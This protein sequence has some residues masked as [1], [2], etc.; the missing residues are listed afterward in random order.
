M[1]DTPDKFEI[2]KDHAAAI[3]YVAIH[4]SLV[5]DH[6]AWLIYNLLGLQTMPG[7]AMTAELPTMQRLVLV[8]TLINLTG[9][10]TWAA[11]WA[12][13]SNEA[14]R[15]RAE[16]NN[17]VHAIWI[18]RDV[19]NRVKAKGKVDFQQ[20]QMKTPEITAKANEILALS[21]KLALFNIEV[22]S[23]GAAKILRQR[24]LP[25]PILPQA[26]LQQSRIR[27]QKRALKETQRQASRREL[28][29]Q[30]EKKDGGDL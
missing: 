3:G 4:W 21:Q 26:P 19:T 17:I 30:R 1:H 18:D 14:D 27:D 29:K 16:R 5:E 12:E 15:L 7:L 25:E 11:K 13:I 10:P 2:K 28:E 22:I 6:I 23:N 24:N 8:R 9:N 20:S